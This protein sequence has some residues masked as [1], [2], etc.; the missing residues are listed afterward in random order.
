MEKERRK[1]TVMIG[2][3]SGVAAGGMVAQSETMKAKE[4]GLVIF[5]GRW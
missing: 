3:L 2:I 4:G 1:S 5:G